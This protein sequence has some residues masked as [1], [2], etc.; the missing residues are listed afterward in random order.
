[1]AEA[2]ELAHERKKAQFDV[3][4]MKVV[5]AGSQ[6]ALQVSNR[7]ANLVASDPV[8]HKDDRPRLSRQEL[9]KKT[10]RKAAHAWK[11]FVDLQLSGD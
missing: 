7:I 8:F 10:L 1:M 5:W 9:F 4:A 3:G 6:H 11:L 2:D